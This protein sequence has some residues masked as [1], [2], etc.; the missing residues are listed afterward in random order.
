MLICVV[1]IT[2]F[3]TYN[4][5]FGSM[6]PPAHE[7]ALLYQ[8]RSVCRRNPYYIPASTALRLG[9]FCGYFRPRSPSHLLFFAPGFSD[10]FS[11]AFV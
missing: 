2:L 5:C 11:G 7:F 3:C 6:I 8:C 9:F 10:A 4:M 1:D